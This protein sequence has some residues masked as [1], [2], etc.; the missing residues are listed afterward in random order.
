MNKIAFETTLYTVNG[1]TIL[2]LPK[3]ASA[4]LPSRGQAMIEGTLNGVQF[5]TPL[6][7]DGAFS[8]WCKVDDSL[9]KAA[10][11]Q[12]GDAV[13]VTMMPMKQWPEPAIPADLQRALAVHAEARALW[14]RVTT[15][16]RWEWIR[17]IRS[18]NRQETRAHRI[19]VACSKLTAGE[20]RPC[21]W[22]RNLSTEPFVSKNGVLLETVKGE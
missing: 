18:T 12:A 19:E 2:R 13:R 16:A 6:E 3:S 17:W 21:C 8:H 22:N 5:Q 7:P 15:M 10:H 20:R 11:V 4:K 1:W 14:Q 9:L